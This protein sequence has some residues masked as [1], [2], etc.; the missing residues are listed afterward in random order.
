MK[1]FKCYDIIILEVCVK[2]RQ[3]VRETSIYLNRKLYSIWKYLERVVNKR[4]V[5]KMVKSGCL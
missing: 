5:A 4:H 3:G 1:T 2:E